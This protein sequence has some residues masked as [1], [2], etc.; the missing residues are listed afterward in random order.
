M[1]AGQGA[2]P[3]TPRRHRR[4]T[5]RIRTLWRAAD[6]SGEGDATTLGGGG[7]FLR[8]PQP[9][10]PATPIE[11]RFRLR[12]DGESHHVR[13]RVVWCH[14]PGRSGGIGRAAGMAVE[15][16]DP[17]AA[18]RVAR[19]LESLPEVAAETAEDAPA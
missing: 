13:G 12:A 15:F 14:T 6:A 2:A 3:R 17:V 7:L 18:A 4:R 11:V 8:T 16:V 10:P 5:V 1:S 19:E 9:L